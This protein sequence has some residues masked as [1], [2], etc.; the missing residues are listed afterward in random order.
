MRKEF[1]KGKKTEQ[2]FHSLFGGQ[3]ATP[4][5]DVAEHWDVA[6]TFGRVDV[7]G[8]KSLKRGLPL[9]DELI[10]IELKNV[11]GKLGWLYGKAD[12]FA[13]Q[14]FNSWLLCPKEALQDLVAKI[15]DKT[16]QSQ[17][18]ICTIYQRKNRKDMLTLIPTQQIRLIS[19]EVFTQSTN[20]D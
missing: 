8:L 11:Q 20:S 16:K 3:L 6:P 14:T 10:W 1:F 13:F 2:E 4:G 5:E 18:P 9:Q 19:Y 15:V 12:Y 17:P 7:K